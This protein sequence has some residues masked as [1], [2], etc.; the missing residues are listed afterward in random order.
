MHIIPECSKQSSTVYSLQL[1]QRSLQIK[2]D[3]LKYK[4]KVWKFTS[5]ILRRTTQY[6]SLYLKRT[7]NCRQE[8][9]PTMSSCDMAI[10][11]S[12]ASTKDEKSE[13]VAVESVE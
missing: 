7:D 10:F 12:E 1:R 9:N 3:S 6:K 5:I 8:R 4:Q 2:I 13:R 11:P